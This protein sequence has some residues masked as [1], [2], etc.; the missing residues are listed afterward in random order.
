MSHFCA[1]NVYIEWS[2]SVGLLMLVSNKQ[3]IEKES[4]AYET[5]VKKTLECVTYHHLNKNPKI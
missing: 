1:K 5:L 4:L 2:D 3:I